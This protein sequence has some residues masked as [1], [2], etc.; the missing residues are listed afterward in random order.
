MKKL[1][2]PLVISSLINGQVFAEESQEE[3][4]NWK[5]SAEIGYVAT[6]GNTQTETLNAKGN[7][8]Y[9][10]DTWRHTGEVTALKASDN[11]I[12]T[13]EKYTTFY[14][15]DYKIKDPNFLFGNVNYENDKF[16]GFEYRATESIGYGR[17][18]VGEEDLTLD[19]EIGPGARQS[20][21]DVGKTQHEAIVRGAVKLAWQISETSKFT[22]V[23]TVES[24]E[25]VTITKSV[26]GLSSKINGYL[27]MKITYT[28]KNTSEVPI[29]LDE[30]DT[31]TA[32]TLV[33]N[34]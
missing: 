30:T 3:K 13:A 26:T 34:F 33:F 14:Q 5:V 6:S 12:T 28:Y 24:G 17:R 10:G 11:N 19:V 20:K 9:D 4:S 1:F 21:P 7:A 8:A 31:E 23:L 27:S 16:S 32:V 2:L 15:V 18:L 25:D 22:E 29:G